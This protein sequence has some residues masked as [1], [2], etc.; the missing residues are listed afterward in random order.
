[1]HR[2]R[3]SFETGSAARGIANRLGAAIAHFR[4][5]EAGAYALMTALLLPVIIGI[6]GLGTE[7]G[8]WYFKHLSMQAA[9]DSASIS[10]AVAN[11]AGVSTNSD[12]Q[13]EAKA[14]AAT[15]GFIDGSNGATVTLNIPPKSGSNVSTPGAMEVIVTQPQSRI[16]S[17]LWA[18]SPINVA[19]SAVAVPANGGNGCVL[20]LDSNAASAISAQGSSAIA[21]NGCNLYDNSSNSTALSVGGSATLSALGVRVAGGISGTSNIT[22]T[23]GIVSGAPAIADPYASVP[24]PECS[25][26]EQK[27]YEKSESSLDP[28]VYQGGIK[29]N[30]GAVVTLNPGVYYLDQGSLTVNGGATLQGSG[31]TLV[32]TSSTGSNYATANI[33]GGATINLTAPTSGATAGI[34]IFGDRNMPVGT[35]LKFAGG[36]SQTLGGAIYAPKAAVSFAGGSGTGSGCTQLVADTIT[37]TGNS[38]FAINCAGYGTKPLGTSTAS[39]VE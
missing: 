34:V 20:A 13:I 21:L 2:S 1:M 25:E 9:A 36:S 29:L 35:T 15:Y 26:C 32:F 10:A 4:R 19:A 28:G 23:N 14:V 7:T 39:L 30:A 37:F 27:E 31:V 18:T 17:S 6:V 22:T 5:D 24:E 38:G 12:L 33:A 11:S 3:Q 8:I 16:F